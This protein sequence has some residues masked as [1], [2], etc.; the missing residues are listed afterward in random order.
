MY[1][2]QFSLFANVQPAHKQVSSFTQ[3]VSN[4]DFQKA[5]ALLSPQLQTKISPL[6]FEQ[7]LGWIEL[8]KSLPVNL[9]STRTDGHQVILHA[10]LIHKDGAQQ[11][12][13]F[14]LS[15]YKN[16]W[17]ID[18]MLLGQDPFSDRFVPELFF[19]P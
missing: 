17:K 7:E 2:R 4:K 6:L 11:P 18:E 15:K 12:A 9:L 14:T 10:T 5:H 3:N 8:N 16:Q 19:S 1:K 13:S